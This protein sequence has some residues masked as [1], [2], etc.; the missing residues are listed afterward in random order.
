MGGGMAGK[1]AGFLGELGGVIGRRMKAEKG[2]GFLEKKEGGFLKISEKKGGG[3]GMGI[4]LR[5]RLLSGM[6]KTPSDTLFCSLFSLELED[7]EE[8]EE[9]AQVEENL[10]FWS[11]IAL[12]GGYCSLTLMVS[13]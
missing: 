2:F 9:V 4:G 3:L 11:G 10:E 5:L 1:D 8:K 6:L 13:R 12:S 7:E